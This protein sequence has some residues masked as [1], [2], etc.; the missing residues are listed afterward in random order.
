MVF[1]THPDGTKE[2]YDGGLMIRIRKGRVVAGTLTFSEG[3]EPYK[4][5]VK[6]GDA[7]SV[8]YTWVKRTNE[9]WV[10]QAAGKVPFVTDSGS[11]WFPQPT[12]PGVKRDD[13]ARKVS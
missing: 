6:L 11:V 4:L 8:G 9:K 3:R 1:V 7:K 12:A 10:D 2:V 5:N 13:K